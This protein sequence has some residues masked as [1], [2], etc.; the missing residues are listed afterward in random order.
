MFRDFPPDIGG[1]ATYAVKIAGELNKLRYPVSVISYTDHFLPPDLVSYPVYGI[2]R[3]NTLNNYFRYFLKVLTVGIRAETLYVL[4]TFSAALPSVMANVFLKKRLV[5]RVGGLFSW[6]Q[7]YQHGWTDMN[8]DNFYTSRTSFVAELLKKFEAW[9]I[10]Q[11]LTVITNSNYMKK[12]L[13][14]AGVDKKKIHIIYNTFEAA[15]V[16]TIK[17]I[18]LNKLHTLR[19]LSAGRLVPWKNFDKL[20]LAVKDLPNVNLCLVGDGPLK[21]PLENII[22]KFNLK[23]RVRL[24][25]QVSHTKM[26]DYYDRYDVFVLLSS[27]EGMSHQLLEAMSRNMPIIASDIEPNREVLADYKDCEFVSINRLTANAIKKAIEKL[28]LKEKIK[29]LHHQALFNRF[30]PTLLFN[31]TYKLL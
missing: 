18:K 27:F 19:L 21:K 10:N 15:S 12:V 26:M 29:S 7:S 31:Q 28:S 2:R 11:A 20:I 13:V 24:I 17:R 3:I 23:H 4:D 9:I 25:G 22:S 1:P 5:I 8:F 30:N 14:K 16:K 6:E